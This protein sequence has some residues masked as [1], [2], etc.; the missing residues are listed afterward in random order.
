[1]TKNDGVLAR[2]AERLARVGVP[3]RPFSRNHGSNERKKLKSKRRF[4]LK[5]EKREVEVKLKRFFLKSSRNGLKKSD[6]KMILD[7]MIL[8]KVLRRGFHLKLTLNS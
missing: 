1:M 5:L 8:N 3:K 2:F 6:L 4:D 7:K